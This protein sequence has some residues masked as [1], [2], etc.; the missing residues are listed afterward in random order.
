[1]DAISLFPLI[2]VG[3]PELQ[4]RLRL[5]K[6]EA[7]SQRVEIVYHVTG[8]TREETADFVR[9]QIRLDGKA[10]PLLTDN[11]L[12]LIY[13]ASRGI[14]RVVNQIRLQALYDAAIKDSEVVD[15]AHI[16]QVLADQE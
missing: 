8:M 11:V 16:Q 9:H 4:R 13:G 5:K 1:M 15:D 7:I 6:Y 14:P 10:A 3:Q 12:H 2:L